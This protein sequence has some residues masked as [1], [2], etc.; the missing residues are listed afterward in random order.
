MMFVQDMKSRSVYLILFPLLAISFIGLYGIQHH[1]LAGYWF[2]PFINLL[3]LFVL[4]LG[5]SAWF[6]LKEKRW[7]NITHHMLGLGD[8]LFLLSITFCF[9]LINYVL[10]FVI[11]L[12]IVLTVWLTAKRTLFKDS[13]H[14][15]LAGL[16]ALI[17]VAALLFAWLK[18]G[19]DLT[20]DTC[21][22]YKIY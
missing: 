6:S 5:V 15:P 21:L 19:I 22:I 20:S 16:Q 14:I 11:S 1:T 9:S 8:I 4:F 17:L 2:T 7:V 13:N 12:I 18:P 3:F 10:F